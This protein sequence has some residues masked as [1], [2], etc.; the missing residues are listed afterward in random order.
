MKK[1][2]VTTSLLMLGSLILLML[3]YVYIQNLLL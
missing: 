1:F 2:L 3:I